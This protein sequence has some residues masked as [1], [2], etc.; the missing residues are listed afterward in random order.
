MAESWKYGGNIVAVWWKYRGS[1]V[2]VSWKYCGST[3]EI[4][5]PNGPPYKIAMLIKKFIG[6]VEIIGTGGEA[7][8][9][10]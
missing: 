10:I 2:V 6:M 3:V 7:K 4:N 1:I 9:V 5:G 8:Q